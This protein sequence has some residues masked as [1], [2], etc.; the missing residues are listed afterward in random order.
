MKRLDKVF[1][2]KYSGS[3]FCSPGSSAVGGDEAMGWGKRRTR[4]ASAVGWCL[5]ALWAVPGSAAEERQPS[6]RPGS[7]AQ[8]VIPAELGQVSQVLELPSSASSQKRLILIEDAHANSEGQQHLSQI[9]ERLASAYGTTLILVEGG[10]G[11]LGLSH[12]RELGSREDRQA[13][14]DEQLK[15]GLLS[16]EEYLDLVSDLPLVLWGVDDLTLYDRQYALFIE[17]EGARAQASTILESLQRLVQ[18][19]R[20]KSSNAALQTFETRQS[21]FDAGRLAFSDYAAYLDQEAVRLGVPR[22]AYPHLAAL[23]E[24]SRLESRLDHEAMARERTAAIDRARVA[25]SDVAWTR[26]TQAAEGVRT[27]TATQAGYDAALAAV[28]KDGRVELD[29]Y[30]ALAAHLR[31][32][33]LRAQASGRAWWNELAGFAQAVRGRLTA[34]E[35]E[36]EL[37]T[38]ADRLARCSRLMRL[39]W[40][41]QDRDAALGDPARSHVSQWLPTLRARAEQAGLTWPAVESARLEQALQP[42][43]RF[44]EISEA[45]DAALVANALSKMDAL[46][47]RTA[48]LIAG[49]FHTDSLVRRL[50]G[51]GVEIAV[52]TPWA[53]S[54]DDPA[55]YASILKAKHEARR[56]AALTH[57]IAH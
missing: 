9:L 10:A 24:A 48:V 41:R 37:A 43:S 20:A 11:P 6:A 34:T 19:L 44:Y 49:G 56:T 8:L 36:R 40:T 31:Y 57:S 5:L 16:G 15:A 52:V 47:E 23:M 22:S 50:A 25:S 18:Q 14:A 55:R 4:V 46:G 3:T 42:A 45:R 27:G 30:P 35:D 13:L 21:A 33:S 32:A 38:L 17:A 28:L 12:L 26:F 7:L 53:S 29:V 54:G 2:K 39:E 51:Q 1:T